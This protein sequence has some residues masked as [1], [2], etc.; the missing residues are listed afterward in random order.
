MPLRIK[1]SRLLQAAKSI[2]LKAVKISKAVQIAWRFI[3]KNC[4]LETRSTSAPTLKNIIG[5]QRAS[6]NKLKQ[7][8]N[9]F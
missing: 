3:A 2:N 9:D 4:E 8:K 6:L 5:M 7:M 1:G